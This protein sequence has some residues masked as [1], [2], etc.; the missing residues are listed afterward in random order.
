MQICIFLFGW[1]AQNEIKIFHKIGSP[2][3]I[4]CKELCLS[5]ESETPGR[6]SFIYS[7]CND[8]VYKESRILIV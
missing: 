3:E 4:Q 1:L 7:A 6:M 2:D 5:A 8:I